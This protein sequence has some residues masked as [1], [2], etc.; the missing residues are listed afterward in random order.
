[1]KYSVI[2]AYYRACDEDEEKL[3]RLLNTLAYQE[4]DDFEVLIV[5]DGQLDKPEV[6]DDYEEFFPIRFLCTDKHYN[7]WGHESRDLGIRMSEGEYLLITNH[8]NNYRKGIFKRI[9]SVLDDK[10]G[11]YIFNVRMVGMRSQDGKI[12]YDKPRDSNVSLILTGNPVE[13][14]NIDIMQ[15]VI[16]RNIWIH[17]KGWYRK[18]KDS[19]GMILRKM[20]KNFRFKQDSFIMGEHN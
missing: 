6:L 1:M 17:Y 19:D 12:G 14:G 5:H 13:V 2:I 10:I 4:Y 11:M 8:D 16:A 15:V 3:L 7:N 18:E 20:S 9:D